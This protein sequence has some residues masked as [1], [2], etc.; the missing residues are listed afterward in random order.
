[1][2]KENGKVPVISTIIAALCI[3]LY[4]GALSY[5]AL[6]I[7][8][9]VSERRALGDREF[10]SLADLAS[11]AGVLGFMDEKFIQ[12]I[13]DAI[14]GSQ[15]I[16]GVVITGSKGEFAF[17]RE[18]G[19]VITWVHNSPRFVPRFAVTRPPRYTALRIEGQRN[20]NIQAVSGYLDYDY[21]IE[22]LKRT[23]LLTLF[24][25]TLAFFTLLMD[26]LLAKNRAPGPPQPVKSPAGEGKAAAAVQ[27]EKKE[28][29]SPAA[30]DQEEDPQ[31]EA[32]AAG[33]EDFDFDD[34]DEF[35]DFD[36]EEI[37]NFLPG[38]GP[39][40]GPPAERK[41]TAADRSPAAAEP[42][43]VE[44]PIPA[45]E[46]NPAEDP[47]LAEERNPEEETP[48]G[49]FSP[50]GNIGWESY[51]EDRLESEL[52]RCA[53]VEQ[54]LAFIVTAFKEPE[55]L[56]KEQFRRFCEE[57][58][59]VFGHRDLIFEYGDQGISVVCPNYTLEQGFAK[60]EEFNSQ[61][62]SKLPR[63]VGSKT[64]LRFGIS[65]RAGRLINAERIMIE[66]GEALSR[67]AADAASHIVAFKSDLEKYRQFIK[68]H[69]ELS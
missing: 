36:D 22:I 44:D 17:E 9:S 4:F 3:I 28:T 61:V 8:G 7:Y 16:L 68:E 65:S 56:S 31:E 48:R 67:A 57:S 26:A 10:D 6:S 62:L 49:L 69:R 33:D 39:A 30:P 38:G 51:T 59:L 40:G 21:C 32:E 14:D 23:L 45:E 53:S 54:D 52:R 58:V 15:T 25:L 37:P 18:R 42:N 41:P 19:T 46:D 2:S 47:I 64:D 50:R 11:A 27:P 20:V 55:R 34:E 66:A 63:P 29:V 24:S 43:P 60:A 13:Q 1:M 35:P 5:G 12:T